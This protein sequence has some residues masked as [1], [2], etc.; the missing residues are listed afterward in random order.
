MNNWGVGGDGVLG[1]RKGGVGRSTDRGREGAP[2][3]TPSSLGWFRAPRKGFPRNGFHKRL[4]E[5]LDPS[6]EA[7]KCGD[8]DS[9][10]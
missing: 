8:V 6:V 10:F 5:T 4:G 3:H 1:G 2:F 7:L 9:L